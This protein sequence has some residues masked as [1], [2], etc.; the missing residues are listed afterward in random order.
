MR[1]QIIATIHKLMQQDK[2]AFFLTGD[3]GYSVLEKIQ[4]DFP[5]RFLN[6]GIAEQNLLGLATGL[7]LS[8][9]RRV[10]VYSIIPFTTLRCAEQIRNDVCFHKAKVTILG[11]GAGLSYGILGSTH[12]AL[13]DI[14]LMRSFPNMKVLSPADGAEASELIKQTHNTDGPFYLR[15]DKSKASF[16]TKG[17]NFQL[18]QAKI[19]QPVA[20]TTIISTGAITLE[21]AKAINELIT[22]EVGLVHLG[23]IK[24]LDEQV[25]QQI[26]QQAKQ[27]IVIEEHG[28]SGGLGEAV[29]SFL[30]QQDTRPK[31]HHFFVDNYYHH[32]T[33]EQAYLRQVHGLDSASL[34][35]R[36]SQ[37]I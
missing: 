9:K 23:T 20:P 29:A 28:K 30:S 32:Q 12:F 6:A 37:I 35:K 17:E 10:Y 3:L 36:I 5:D 25:L 27:V 14:S 24:P 34:T 31:L 19:I 26:S 4:T 13:E 33:G 7:S 2:S 15:I 16:F 18:G 8:F 11:I 22:S 1:D 21:A